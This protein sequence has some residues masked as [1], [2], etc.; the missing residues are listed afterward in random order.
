MIISRKTVIFMLINVFFIYF[1]IMM[2]LSYLPRF[3]ENIGTESSIITLT[4]TVFMSTFFIFPPFLGK[5]SDRLQNR[6]YFILLGTAGMLCMLILLVFAKNIIVLNIELFILGFF[7]SFSS[8]YLTL[9]SEL[10]QNDK[11]WISYYN[12]DCA[13]GWFLGVVIGGLW[14][15]IFSV[16][17]IIIF[18]LMIFLLSIIFV[19]FIR[20]NRQAILN[21]NENLLK[22]INIE[23]HN[24]DDNIPRS[25][26]YSIFFRNFGVVPILNI[27]II[28]MS[29]HISSNSEIGLLIGINPL[30]QFFF[31]LIMG[32]VLSQ[33]NF[34][35]FL[36]LGYILTV[37]VILGYIFS[38]NF[39]GFFVFQ[40]L[41]SLSYSMF[42]MATIV[43]LAQNSTPVNKGRFMGYANT[44][45]FAGTTI[46][47]LFFSMLLG[48]FNSN[49]YIAM[50]FMII[51][52]IISTLIMSKK[53]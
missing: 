46:G 44:S 10:V 6:I 8:I 17:T 28:I 27:I 5:Y 30:M 31:I 40:V 34:K 1:S 41:V 3:L 33:K 52:P 35:L 53:F 29:F 18:S 45:L 15:D 42:W 11:K 36:I 39:W 12:A 20:E 49:Y 50:L 48:I 21:A 32:K 14:I 37:I 38:N 43:Y 9:Y 47:G 13:I 4:M 25:L 16:E 51:F 26:F 22:N 19:I 23:I 24:K 2:L 7:S